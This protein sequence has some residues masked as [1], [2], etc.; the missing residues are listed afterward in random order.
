MFRKEIPFAF[1]GELTLPDECFAFDLI[2]FP[3]LARFFLACLFL[4]CHGLVW[5]CKAT[6]RAYI[7]DGQHALVPCADNAIPFACGIY[8]KRRAAK[9]YRACIIHY[10]YISLG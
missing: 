9:A 8:A 2:E 1:R 6:G 7:R 3:Q 4:F 5:A 10:R